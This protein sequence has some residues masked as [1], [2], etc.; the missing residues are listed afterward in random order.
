RRLTGKSIDRRPKV[1]AALVI[2]PTRPRDESLRVP[3]AR[4]DEA[5][6]LARALDLEIR[7][8]LIVPLRSTTPATLFGSGKVDEIA[9]ICDGHEI[10]VVVVDDALSPVQ[11]RN[12][13]R[14]WKV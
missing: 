6:G 12:L 3:A 4:L 10:D 2:H 5:T 9:M 8:A 11:Q 13:E 7:Q 14:A 1:Q